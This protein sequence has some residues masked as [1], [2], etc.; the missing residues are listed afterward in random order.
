M[1][2]SSI[3]L[4]PERRPIIIQTASQAKE[5]N[6][7][8]NHNDDETVDEAIVRLCSSLERTSGIP[9]LFC[10]NDVIARTRAES[11]GLHTF[12][13]EAILK[14]ADRRTDQ[15]L[16]DRQADAHKSMHDPSRRS[17]AAVSQQERNDAQELALRDAASTLLEQWA[18]QILPMNYH[19]SAS[20]SSVTINPTTSAHA[21]HDS[22]PL[23]HDPPTTH[24][25]HSPDLNPHVSWEEVVASSPQTRNRYLSYYEKRQREQ[26]YAQ[27]HSDSMALDGDAS[28]EGRRRAPSTPGRTTADS[29]WAR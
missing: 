2:Y 8:H 9:V 20:T 15:I 23:D 3:T 14:F 4:P 6:K 19:Q 22:M 27:Q 1:E 10:S 29:V 21:P 26:Q 11:Q 28:S 7:T 12:D 17:S 25:T 24:D 5:Y 16:N 13:L 18:E